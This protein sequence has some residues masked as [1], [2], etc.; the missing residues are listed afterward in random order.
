MTLIKTE[1]HTLACWR[2]NCW[3]LALRMWKINRMMLLTY[4]VQHYCQKKPEISFRLLSR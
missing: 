3:V 1:Q 2:M 4:S